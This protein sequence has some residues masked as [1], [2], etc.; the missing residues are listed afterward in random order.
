MSEEVGIESVFV[1]TGPVE[2][3]LPP[4]LEAVYP[5][6]GAASVAVSLDVGAELDPLEL[7]LEP[8]DPVVGTASVA[9]LL[10]TEGEAESVD[11]MSLDAELPEVGTVS[12]AVMLGT[13]DWPLPLEGVTSE[14]ETASVL[15]PIAGRLEAGPA[16]VDGGGGR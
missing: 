13:E 3:A 4:P 1:P 9:V 11:G 2:L 15:V 10:D 14:V 16:V 8:G 12:V 7:A 5:D 6:V